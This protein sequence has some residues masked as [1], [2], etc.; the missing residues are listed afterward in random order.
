MLAGGYGLLGAPEPH[1]VVTVGGVVV[2]AVG[3]ADV[4]IVVVPRAAAQ[5]PYARSP[6]ART[7]ELAFATPHLYRN[8]FNRAMK[9]SSSNRP[10]CAPFQMCAL[11][12][13]DIVWP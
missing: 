5:D 13:H 6:I 7:S 10:R 3:S 12:L 1:V 8:W 2:V 9:L 11:C 4:V